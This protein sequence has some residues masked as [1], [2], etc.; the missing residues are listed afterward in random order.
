MKS[1][2][3]LLLRAPIKDYQELLDIRKNIMLA[4]S[5]PN[6]SRTR[7]NELISRYEFTDVGDLSP[8]Y[9]SAMLNLS[10]ALMQLEQHI[11]MV[12]N[13]RL[14][15]FFIV[16][17]SAGE[18]PLTISDLKVTLESQSVVDVPLLA[19]AIDTMNKFVMEY[20][21]VY[22]KNTAFDMALSSMNLSEKASNKYDKIFE[23]LNPMREMYGELSY[24]HFG[25][26][27]II[28]TPGEDS[29]TQ[30]YFQNQKGLV[31]IYGDDVI[32]PS[33]IYDDQTLDVLFNDTTNA[34]KIRAGFNYTFEGLLYD[35]WVL[36]N[37][38][39]ADFT[40]LNPEDVSYTQREATGDIVVVVNP[41]APNE[42]EELV[43][44]HSNVENY[45]ITQDVNEYAVIARNV[46]VTFNAILA[47]D[48]SDMCTFAFRSEDGSLRLIELS[49][50]NCIRVSSEAE[51][52]TNEGLVLNNNLIAK[53]TIDS[54]SLLHWCELKASMEWGTFSTLLISFSDYIDR[55]G[56]IRKEYVF[57]GSSTIIQYSIVQALRNIVKNNTFSYDEDNERYVS[58]ADIVSFNIFTSQ[59]FPL[60]KKKIPELWS[61]F[62]DWCKWMLTIMISDVQYLEWAERGGN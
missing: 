25:F 55:N 41:G 42:V 20:A 50:K 33:M 32:E 61:A 31:S 52:L 37:S 58:L 53:N 26:N 8:S 43:E 44:V 2:L 10:V 23:Y 54:M 15:A 3:L 28:T 36:K 56:R 46:V 51:Y 21:D 14:R 27:S 62:I 48:G 12:V 30:L 6:S 60:T 16:T 57:E 13:P 17:G 24:E 18:I 7:F 47:D 59:K 9:Q 4:K 49:L 35:K 45:I 29:S 11:D 22:W 38:T 1:Q 40:A 19:S 34:R 5:V 39:S